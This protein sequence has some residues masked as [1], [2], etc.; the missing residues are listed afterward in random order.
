[1]SADDFR[2][3]VT[4]WDHS[5]HVSLEF[6]RWSPPDFAHGEIVSGTGGY[7]VFEPGG[8]YACVP[9]VPR[10]LIEKLESGDRERDMI[11]VWQWSELLDATPVD[12]L[13]TIT[14]STH[15]KPDRVRN[16]TTGRVYQ[17][18]VQGDYADVAKVNSAVCVLVDGTPPAATP[19][20]E[21][22]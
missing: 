3:L 11:L 7:T 22:P 1:M 18:A 5:A 13:Q 21:P 9:R 19:I 2:D 20:P 12:T 4:E 15:N 17:V 14:Q 10:R 16:T 6:Q 8:P